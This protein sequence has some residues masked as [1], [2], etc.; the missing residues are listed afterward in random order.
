LYYITKEIIKF[1]NFVSSDSSRTS[2][3]GAAPEIRGWKKVVADPSTGHT[4]CYVQKPRTSLL[5]RLRR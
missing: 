1:S 5:S 3:F 4:I 2:T